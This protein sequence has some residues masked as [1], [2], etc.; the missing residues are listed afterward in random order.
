MPQS[1][2]PED[3]LPVPDRPNILCGTPAGREIAADRLV[4]A[5]LNETIKIR[6][7][8]SIP[9]IAFGQKFSRE[10]IEVFFQA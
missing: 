10:R 6:T 2:T 7:R 9:R 5:Q 3:P 8:V 1:R 4:S